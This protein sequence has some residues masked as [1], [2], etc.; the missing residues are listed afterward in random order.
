MIQ[1]P[2]ELY[3]LLELEQWVAYQLVWNERKGKLDKVPKNPLNGQNASSTDPNTW[4]TFEIASRAVEKFGFDG[5]GFE[6]GLR[7]EGNK[8]R[9]LGIDLDH[10]IRADGS[11]EPFAEEIVRQI[12]S[13][14]EISPSGEGLHIPCNADLPD[15][16]NKT[17][18]STGCALEM[19]NHSR[20]FTVTGNVFRDPRPV[21]DRT[22]ECRTLHGQY[23]SKRNTTRTKKSLAVSSPPA[24]APTLELRDALGLSDD[25]LLEKMFRSRN[26]DNIRR[27][28]DGDISDY[29]SQSEA[30]LAL[31][32]H[33]AFCTQH[34][35]ERV[36]SLFRRSKLM[37]EKWNKEEYRR[38]TMRTALENQQYDFDPKT[39]KEDYSL[40]AIP[41]QTEL[42]LGNTKCRQV[43][44]YLKTGFADDTAHF[45]ECKSRKIGYSNIDAITSLYPGLYIIGAVTSLGKTTFAYRMADQ[46]AREGKHVLYFTLE[47]SI[48]EL[49]PKGLSRITAQNDLCNA[50]CAIKIREGLQSPIL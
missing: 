36:D 38:R 5:V 27:L 19:Y 22:S 15:I 14:T 8:K 43:A 46:L 30:D 11:L 47:Q 9:V 41:L 26:G 29:P 18:L 35:E 49:V 31:C 34:D 13:Y 4:S 33:L 39:P 16:G 3:V 48:F 1:L 24:L 20:Y 37:R 12:D 7:S 25:E 32:G 21:A 23:F 6:F 10:V 17:P 2:P 45:S 40:S 50:I 42:P 44:N 28:F